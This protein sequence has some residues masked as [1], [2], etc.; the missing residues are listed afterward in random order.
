MVERLEAPPESVITIPGGLPGLPDM[1]RVVLIEPEDLAPIL[2]L[3]SLQDKDLSLPVIPAHRVVADYRPVLDPV[4]RQAL[5]ISDVEP[6]PALLELVVVVLDSQEGA[7]ACNLFAPILI[8]PDKRIGR[9][10]LQIG[11]DYPSLFH[12][13][14]E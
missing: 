11:S 3:Q 7:A 8:H 4:D 13:E 5:G 12:L 1:E 6:A 10:C 14:V 9:Q 2:L